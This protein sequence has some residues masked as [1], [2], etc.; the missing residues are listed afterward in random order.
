MSRKTMLLSATLV[1]V[2]L[3]PQPQASAAQTLGGSAVPGVCLLSRPALIKRSRIGQSANTR[4]RQLVAQARAQLKKEDASLRAD[5]STFRAHAA[6]LSAAERKKQELS[7]QQ[8]ARAARVRTAVMNRR[9]RLTQ[10]Q[11]TRRILEE[12]QPVLAGIYKSK[13]CGLLLKRDM[14]LGGNLRNDLTGEVIQGLDK[15]VTTIQFD[16]VALPKKKAR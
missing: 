1:G 15:K 11:I 9:I 14:V 6:T 5:V 12:A 3:L 13:G 7:L 16:L 8:R 2:L 10:V 4:L